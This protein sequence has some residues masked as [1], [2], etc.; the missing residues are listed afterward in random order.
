MSPDSSS[1]VK[2]ATNGLLA[3]LAEGKFEPG[4]K[5]PSERMLAETLKLSRT[6][7]RHALTRLESAGILESHPKRGWFLKRQRSFTDRSTLLES[8][9]EVAENRGFLPSSQIIQTETR[10]SSIDEA[11]ALGIPPGSDVVKIVRVRKL[12][13]V[14]VCIDEIV[15]PSALGQPILTMDLE[16]DSI[17]R[18][19]QHLCGISVYKSSYSLEAKSCSRSQ[20][21]LLGITAGE[22]ILEASARTSTANGQVVILSLT[23]HRGDSYRFQ[24]ELYRGNLYF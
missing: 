16:N 7:M 8:F 5:L 15:L 12:D 1:T 14:P 10:T 20:A 13:D 22:P 11:Q 3:L 4:A 6:T 21:S 2:L 9:T 23:H 19:L 17:Y 18:G 24:A